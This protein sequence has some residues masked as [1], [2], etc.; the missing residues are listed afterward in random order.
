MFRVNILVVPNTHTL[1][2]LV[3]IWTIDF[4]VFHVTLIFE[5][6]FSDAACN[7]PKQQKKKEKERQREKRKNKKKK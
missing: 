5:Q 7:R 3:E 6:E 1:S 2:Q 4:L